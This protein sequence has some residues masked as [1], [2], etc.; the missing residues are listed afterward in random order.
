M[1]A[2]SRQ[3]LLTGAL[4]PLLLP[5]CGGQQQPAWA[6]QHATLDVESDGI[7]GY[8]LWEL[9]AKKWKKKQDDKHHLCALVQT[10]DGTLTT[11]LDGCLG[12]EASYAVTVDELETD[13][14]PTWVAGETFEGVRAF[15]FGEVP[16]EEAD[17]DPYPGH[18]LGWYQSWDGQTAEFIGFAWHE[19]LGTAS[20]PGIQGWSPGERYVLEPVYA[21]EL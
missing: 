9:F 20:D 16:P 5:A 12:C 3:A 10:V 15:A 7:S 4:L 6:V 13:C 2:R 18:S 1:R 11:D 19:A 17:L 8:Q 14:D 21:W